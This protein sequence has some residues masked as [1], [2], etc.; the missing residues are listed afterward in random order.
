MALENDA[1]AADPPL[2]MSTWHQTANLIAVALPPLALIVSVPLLWGELVGWHD[3]VIMAFMYFLTVLGITLGY[4]RL[5]THR[6]FETYKPVKYTLA[7]LGSMAAQGQVM[8]WVADHRRHHAYPDQEGD[9][10][11][12]HGHGSGVIGAVRG[13]WHAHT[14]WLFRFA[15]SAERKRY[16]RDLLADNGLR[17]IDRSFLIWVL[18]GLAI[19]FGLG[20]AIT[21]SWVGGLTAVLWGGAVRLLLSHHMTFSINSVCHFFGRRP[22]GSDD[23]S[24]NVFWLAIPSLGE[25]WHNGHHAFPT[26][27][28]HGLL[29]G[30]V[31]I[32]Y[33]M[34]KLLEKLGLAWD[35][36]K[37]SP[38]RITQRAAANH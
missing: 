23:E 5:L 25:A 33:G 30:Q 7:V 36:V 22:F 19:P 8:T 3:L 2:P 20:I 10:H 4:H 38:D 28:K 37:P 27:A 31:D 11:T 1:L 35:I 32:T 9:P 21:G 13:L 6:S 26:S 24:R 15:G 14:G 34:I 18:L 16:V 12:P 29:R 17:F